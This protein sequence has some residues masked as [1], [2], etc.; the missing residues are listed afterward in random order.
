M[1]AADQ[2]RRRIERDLHDGAQQRLVSLAL[3]LRIAQGEVSTGA[4]ELRMRLDRAIEQVRGALEELRDLSRGIHPAILTE[5]GLGSALREVTGR[6]PIPVQL[7]LGVD[8]R[9]PDQVEFSAYYIVAEA[10]TNAA[11]HSGASAITVTSNAI[12]PPR[13]CASR[14]PTT[15]WEAPNS[16]AAP[17]WS[18][19]R[20]GPR[21]SA[22]T[23]SYTAPKG[24]NHPANHAS[25][26]PTQR[27]YAPRATCYTGFGALAPDLSG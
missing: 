12:P 25:A 10:L 20:T 3:E 23:S 26:R 9:R 2:T 13:C 15:A 1:A 14:S 27:R 22:A 5:G 24:R 17:A 21:R 6:S 11:K 18:C 19:S 4:G 8:E 7:Q 16:P